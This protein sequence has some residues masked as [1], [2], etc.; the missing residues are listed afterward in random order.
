MKLYVNEFLLDFNL[1]S[2][3][4][5]VWKKGVC[6]YITLGALRKLCLFFYIQIGE[7]WVFKI[8]SAANITWSFTKPF[9]YRRLEQY[10]SWWNP[11]CIYYNLEKANNPTY[12]CWVSLMKF[13]E[14]SN[15]SIIDMRVLTLSKLLGSMRPRGFGAFFF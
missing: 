15:T 7:D 2:A 8:F 1:L 12:P 10:S 9:W 6:T 13:K 4:E 14:I 11:N 3:R 5:H